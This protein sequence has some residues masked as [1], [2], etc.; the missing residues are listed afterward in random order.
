MELTVSLDAQD[1][2]YEEKKRFLE[3]QGLKASIAFPL[4][5]DRYTSE[6]MQYLRLCCL[7]ASDG[8]LD[9]YDYT[10]PLSSSN[11]RAA[12][13][14]L[15]QGCEDALARYPESEAEDAALMENSKLFAMCTRN[16]RMAVKLRRNEKR[17]LLRTIRPCDTALDALEGRAVSA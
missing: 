11:E 13:S 2:R 5:I 8:P 14:A 10:E 15:R 16:Q 1:L 12:L 9:S 17:I 7:T 4:L 3:A 6:L